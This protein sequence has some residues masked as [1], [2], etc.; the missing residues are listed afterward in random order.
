MIKNIWLLLG[1]LLFTCCLSACSV[2]PVSDYQHGVRNNPGIPSPY[3]QMH[4]KI[5]RDENE[6]YQLTDFCTTR[7][8]HIPVIYAQHSE[9]VLAKYRSEYLNIM[10]EVEA[11]HKNMACGEVP[12]Q[13]GSPWDSL[14]V[15]FR[16]PEIF[17]GSP[18]RVSAS[19]DTNYILVPEECYATPNQCLKKNEFL[20]F[21]DVSEHEGFFINYK[22]A[23]SALNEAFKNVPVEEYIIQAKEVFRLDEEF[24][25]VSNAATKRL[26]EI[27][28]ISDNYH[29]KEERKKRSIELS[30]AK[31]NER[32]RKQAQESLF[33][34]LSKNK[35]ELGDQVCT[36][37]NDFGYVEHVSG[38]KIQI[39]VKGSALDQEDYLFFTPESINYSYVNKDDIIWDQSSLWAACTFIR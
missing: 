33:K 27:N 1:I 10:A 20:E 7:S 26:S 30:R 22:K 21:N 11:T 18:A 25:R 36:P 8:N 28:R 12:N 14:Y 37:E 15:N 19:L 24:I 34:T 17:M 13:Q 32:K 35:K 39:R 5:T 2:H 23:L 6:Q 31:E 9:R 29:A 38:A 3:F 4:A 16:G